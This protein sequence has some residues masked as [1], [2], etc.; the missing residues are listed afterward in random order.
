MSKSAMKLAFVAVVLGTMGS[1]TVATGIASAKAGAIVTCDTK[2][3]SGGASRV[4]ATAEA[5]TRAEAVKLAM[6]DVK[7]QLVAGETIVK[8]STR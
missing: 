4:S 8:C 6:A 2:T 3:K 5:P 1:L 7:R